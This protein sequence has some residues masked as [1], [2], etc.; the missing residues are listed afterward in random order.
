[1]IYIIQFQNTG[2]HLAPRLIINFLLKKTV[3]YEKDNHKYHI[4]SD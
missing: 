2:H 4:N 3:I 1:M